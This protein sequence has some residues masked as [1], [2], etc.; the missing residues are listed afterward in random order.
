MTFLERCTGKEESH[1]HVFEMITYLI[2]LIWEMAQWIK[3]LPCNM[4]NLVTTQK[5]RVQHRPLTLVLVKREDDC[6]GTC[7]SPIQAN[8][9]T[10]GLHERLTLSS[11]KWRW[12][13]DIPI[14][15]SGFQ[16]QSQSIFTTHTQCYTK[17]G[18][19]PFHITI[20]S[21][22]VILHQHLLLFW[23]FTW[24]FSQSHLSILS[25]HSL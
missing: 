9:R 10:S 7:S 22:L 11:Y 12:L 23:S 24:S 3:C 16:E 20:A 4:N 2:F 14:L 17:G 18:L 1:T 13:K 25:S 15:I 6:L 21:Y 5:P 8:Q 19:F